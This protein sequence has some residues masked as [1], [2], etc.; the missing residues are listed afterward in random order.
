MLRLP[1]LP[2]SS[3][4]PCPL[5]SSR[6]GSPGTETRS[7]SVQAIGRQIPWLFV[8]LGN[9][10]ANYVGTR[11]NVGFEMIDAIADAE[12]IKLSSIQHKSLVGK[13]HINGAPVLLA[14]PQTFMNLSGE[15]VG[16]MAAYYRIP[17]ERVLVMYD[18]MDLAFAVMRLLPK[19][20]HGGHNGMKSIMTHLKGSRDFPRLRIGVGRPPGKMDPKSFVLQKFTALEREELLLSFERG[21]EAVRI[22]TRDGLEKGVSTW[23]ASRKDTSPPASNVIKTSE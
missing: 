23:N 5:L 1:S 6:P 20:G 7:F 12:G 4:G 18:D 8:G 13:G 2:S 14:K 10:G 9:P 17:A 11:H 3:G 15:A 19:G 22:V 21:I 16:P